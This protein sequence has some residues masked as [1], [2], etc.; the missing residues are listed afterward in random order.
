[1]NEYPHFELRIIDQSGD[2]LT[3]N[4]LKPFLD[5]PR[6]HYIRTATQ[7]VS[8]G[9]NLGIC[10]AKSELIAITDDDCEI[11]KNWL[12]E[13][14]AGL[15]MDSKIGIVFGNVI[16]GPHNGQVGY[17]PG[18]HRKEPF[19]AH[20]IFEKHQVEGISAC[21]GL[22]RSVWQRLGG[23]DPM[24]GGGAPMKSGGEGDLTIRAL[25]AG[26]SVYETPKITV[27][28]HGF[29]TWE[30][31][32]T[33]IQGY[34]YGTGAMLVKHLKCGHLSIVLLLLRLAW[35]WAFGLSRVGASLGNNP[36]RSLRLTSF[37]RGFAAGA[38]IPVDKTKC[39]FIHQNKRS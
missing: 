15:Y 21:M 17:I 33:H 5:H 23:F 16:P 22:R 27:I 34:W 39:L 26:Y 31:D 35:R 14:V 38:V 7:G 9:R 1:L 8:A 11:P 24:L 13:L 19:L 28:H 25:L 30:Q 37:I 12:Q 20:S 10:D 6:L 29:R 3:E 32:R 4:S 2:D 36:H 18:Y